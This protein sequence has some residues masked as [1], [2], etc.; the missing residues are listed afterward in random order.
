[1]WRCALR[2]SDEKCS[3][4]TSTGFTLR[5]RLKH[6][7]KIKKLSHEV[8][9][10]R[11]IRLT[12]F[13]KVVGIVERHVP[14]LHKVGHR[15]CHRSADSGKTMHKNTTFLLSGFIWKRGK[16]DYSTKQQLKL[17]IHV[18]CNWN[19]KTANITMR[20]TREF[21]SNYCNKDLRYSIECFFQPT[22]SR[23]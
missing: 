16:W 11:N 18:I 9:I 17:I 3:S 6:F 5:R 19:R 2:W 20:P 12:L 14:F 23:P 22:P 1:M 10:R 21:Q 13:Y 7:F 15:H 8:E 4:V